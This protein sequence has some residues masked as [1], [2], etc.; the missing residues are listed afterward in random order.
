MVDQAAAVCA[1]NS[2]ELPRPWSTQAKS[3]FDAVVGLFLGAGKI[4]S[5]SFIALGGTDILEEGKWRDKS[6]RGVSSLQHITK[7]ANSLIFFL[8]ERL[9]E[10]LFRSSYLLKLL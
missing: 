4:Q 6:R 8:S 5:G 2:A 1:G 7:T 9:F 3:D 10:S